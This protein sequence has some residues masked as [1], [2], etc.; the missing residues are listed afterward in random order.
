MPERARLLL[1][2]AFVWFPSFCTPQPASEQNLTLALEQLPELQRMEAA[3]PAYIERARLVLILA[4]PLEHD[5][6]PGTH[7]TYGSW[8]SRGSRCAS[9]FAVCRRCGCGGVHLCD[10]FPVPLRLLIRESLPPRSRLILSSTLLAS[11]ESHLPILLVE[12]A[13]AAPR[14]INAT[15]A[16]W[17]AAV[18]EGK[19]ACCTLG[20]VPLNGFEVECERVQVGPYTVP[21]DMTIEGQRAQV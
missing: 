21:S 9:A 1:P 6:L 11:A 13:N 12:S 8:C 17:S 15:E 18:G 7:C 16:A 19:F 2:D 20:H 10:P 4:P 3:I 14:F 5:E